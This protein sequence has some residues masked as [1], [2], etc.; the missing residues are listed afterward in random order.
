[1]KDNKRK[2]GLK[3]AFIYCKEK[4]LETN[5]QNLILAYKA[6]GGYCS[7]TKKGFGSMHTTTLIK[8]VEE[9]KNDPAY[10]IFVGE[11]IV[12]KTHKQ[13]ERSKWYEMID[14]S[15]KAKDNYNEIIQ[16]FPDVKYSTYK[17]QR[18]R[19]NHNNS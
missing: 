13:Q 11:G 10:R 8:Y 6:C 12:R 2:E 5:E 19:K 4:G 1:M 7:K 14:L 17:N 18:S 15:V 9:M 3:Y 16:V